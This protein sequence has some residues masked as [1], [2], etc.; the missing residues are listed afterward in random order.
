VSESND[1]QMLAAGMGPSLARMPVSCA[2]PSAEIKVYFQPDH[3]I[4]N[5]NL[6]DA[7]F[8][9]EFDKL[10]TQNIRQR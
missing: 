9:Q 5:V 10:Y 7:G 6:I 1:G 8:N 3:S 4:N 2:N